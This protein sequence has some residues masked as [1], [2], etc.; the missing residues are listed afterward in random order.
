MFLFKRVLQIFAAV[1]FNSFRTPCVSL[2]N[3]NSIF[4]LIANNQIPMF[5]KPVKLTTYNVRLNMTQMS[6][7]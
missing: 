6:V 7:L 4:I 5:I 2:A 1:G 3:M